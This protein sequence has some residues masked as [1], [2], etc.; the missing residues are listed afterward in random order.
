M[1]SAYETSHIRKLQ[2]Q[3]KRMQ[4][5]TFTNWI[6]NIF[7][8]GRV[9]IKIQNLYTELADGTHLL[10]LLEI[11]SGESLPPPSRGRMRAHFLEN[12]SRAL[13]FLK[14][15]VPIPLIGPEN[16]VDGDQTLILGLIWVI[17]LRFQISHI[18][19]DREEFGASA[20]LLS[21]KEALLVW[22]Q[23]KTACYANVN[24]TD[25][26]R[27]WSDGLGFGALIH[28]HRP[29]LL[30]YCSLRPERP[31]HN[32][33]L[34]F[35]VAEQELGIAQLLDPEDVAALQPDE[36]SIMTYISLYYHHFSRL[37][38]EQTVQRRLAK[39][40]LQLQETEELQTQY[41]QLVGDL[42]GWIAEKQAQL[43]AHDFPNSLP[44][45][46]QLLVTFA[47]FRTQEKPPRLQQRGAIE[48][49]LF[50]LQTAFRAQN[51]KPFL[52]PEGLGPAELSQLWTCLE[53]AEA[54][55]SQALLQRILQLERLEI[56]VRRFQHKAALRESFL[57]DTEHML[58][59]AA[60]ASPPASLATVEV[61]AQRLGMLEASILPQEGRFQALAEITD[62][63]QQQQ[64]PGWEEVACR[65]LEITGRWERLLERLQG[66]KKQMAD[67]QAMLGL[68][69][70]VESASNQLKEL[71]VLA[72]STA[73]G[74]LLAET[75]ELLQKHD[76][77]EA[78]VSA[79]GAHVRHLALQTMELDSSL[80]TGVEVLQAKAQSL[81]QLHWSLVSLVKARRAL[82]EQ[83]LQ[84]AEFLHHCEEEEA[85]LKERGRLLEDDG[86]L[87]P[88]LS[89]IRAALQKH[90]A[91]EAELRHH[92]N[93]CTDLVRRGCDLSAR[94]PPTRPDPRERA[95][96]LQ[97]TWQW[98]RAGAARRGARLQAALLARQY[99]AD[100][101][102]A[103]SWLREQ[104]LAMKSAP[105]GPDPEATEALLLHHRQLE[106]AV[107][108]FGAEMRQLDEQARAAAAQV[109]LTVVSALSSP[110]KALSH[111]GT[112][113]E[114]SCY[115]SP[116]GTRKMALS[117]GPDAIFDPNTI[118]Q[119]QDCLSRDYE[120][121]RALAKHH[122]AR[123]EEAI[124]LWGFHGF[125]GEL[126]SWLEKQ[127]ALLQALQPQ[128][129]NLEV[130]QLTYENFLTTLA[131][132]R[133]YWAEVS[134]NAE[135]LKQRYPEG[136][137]RIQQQQEELSQR[138]G[139]MEAL[140]KEKET[141]LA[142]TTDV[143]TFLHECG[144]TQV[145]LQDL[146][147]QLE[148]LQLGQ[149]KDSHRTL[150]LAQQ[151]MLMLERRV[152]YLQR[153]AMKAEELGP[154]ES[155][156]L[157]EEVEPLWELLERGQQ[158][159]ARQA[160]AWAE[161]RARQSF[162]QESQQLLLWVEGIWAQLRREEKVMD[163][164]SAQQLLME[165]TDLQVE[166]QLQQERLQQLEAQG[167]TLSVLDSPDSQEVART[168][169][170][171]GEQGPGLQA[172][173]EQRRQRLQ[174]GLEL[175]RFGGDVDGFTATCARHEAFL[176]RDKLGD[177]VG[178]AQSLLQQHRD[179]GWLLGI[180]GHQA[181]AL[182][183]RGEKLALSQHPAAHKVQEQL[184]SVQAQWTR[185]QERSEQTRRRLLASLQLQEWQQ[186]V[187]G[188]VLWIEE[189]G[190]RAAEEP[191]REP[192]DILQQAAWH[193][194][195]KRELLAS[196]GHVEG[197]QQAGRRL[198]SDGHCAGEAVQASLQG[199]SSKWEELKNKLARQG[200]RLLQTRQLLGLLQDAKEKMKQLE[201]SL[202]STETGQDLG[203]SRELQKWHGQLESESQA[204]ASKMAAVV[205]QAHQGL[206]SQTIVEETQKYLQRFKSL[207]GPLAARRL[208]L[209]ASV[210]LH[211]FYQLS[212]LELTWVAERM[213]R[214][215]STQCLNQAQRLCHKH[216]E[217]GAEM[218]A[219]QGQ[220]QHVLGS[221]QSLAASG[222]PEASRVLEQCQKLEGHWA[223]L[224]RTWE[225]QAQCLQQA[226]ALQQCFLAASELEDWVK[227]KQPLVDSEDCGG[228]E[229][230]TSR[231]IKKNQ[232]LQ[233][234]LALCWSSMEKL[235]QR[236]QIL[237][238]P[239]APEHLRVVRERLWEQ[240]RAL[241][242]RAATRGRE[243]EGTLKLHEFMGEAEELRT[244]LASQKQ[245]AG[246]GE[247]LGEDHEHI[248][249]LCTEFTR[250][251]RRVELGALRVAACRQ[252]AESLQELGHRAA[253]DARQT[254]QHL[255]AAWSELWE[256][257]QARGHQLQ[258]AEVTLRV[259]RDLLEALTQVQE[260]A[261]S[262]PS[263][264]APDLHGLEAQL[265]RH[266]ELEHELRGAGQQLQELLEAA[267]AV[268]KLG[269]GPQAQAV[270]QR[271]EALGQAWEA[272]KLHVEQRRTRLEQACLLARFHRAVQDYTSW[273]AA[274]WREL[275]GQEGSQEPGHGLPTLLS[276]HRQLRAELEAREELHQ[277]ASQ[278]G[279][280]ALLAVV[281]TP[282]KEVQ[283]G[284]RALRDE[285]EQVFQAWEQKEEK[286]QAM[287]REQLFLRKCGHLDQILTVQE[288]S[289]KTGALGSSV[290]EVEQLIRKHKTFQNVLTA[291][292]E[293]EA[294]L[295]EQAKT[296]GGP[297]VQDRL[298]TV[299][300]H[301]AQV[302]D[303][304]ESR[305]QALHTCL[306]M[307]GF[308][309]AVTQ[310]QDWIEER[311]RQLREPIPPGDL[312]DKLRLLRK[313]QAFEAE[314]QAHEEVITSV[315]KDGE[316]LLAQSPPQAG[317]VSQ[318][319]QDLQE[320]WRKLRQAVVL[321]GQD[322]EDR[323]K[324]L[325]FLR[326]ADL[327]DAWIQEMEA[328]V[329]LGEQGQ[330]LEHCLQLRKRLRE[331]PGLWAEDTVDDIH[332]RSISDLS[333][334]LGNL[335]PEQV[336]T[337]HK[338]RQQLNS[339]WKSFRGNLLWYQQQLEGALEIHTL[340]RELDGVTEQIGEKAAL[341]QALDYG[342][343]Q[344]SLQRL[345]R[346]HKELEQEIGL[347]QAQVESLE[348]A[349]GR[350]CQRSP[351]T[352]H[353]LSSKQ[354][355]VT[356]S[357]WQLWRGA[358]KRRES[359]EALYE[360]QSLQAELRHL[361]VWAQG[362]RAEMEAQS[363]PSS[364]AEA[365]RRL[366][367]HQELKAELDLKTN[368]ISLARSTGQ[369]LLAAGHPAPPDLRQALAGLDQ[370]LNSLERA[371]Q[372]HQLQLQQALELQ[373]V[374]SSVEQM[375]IWLCSQEACPT[376]KGLGD[377]WAA[378][379]TLL[380][381]HEVLERG[382]EAQ[383]EKM[384][385]LEAAARRLHQAGYPEAQG[386][387][388]RCQAMLLRKEAL[389]ERARTR[390]RQLEEL[391]QLQTFLQDSFEVATWLR[392][393]HSVALEE[394]WRDPALLQAQLRKQRS[395]QAELDASVHHHQ[396][397]QKEGQRLLQE[398]HPASE[399]IRERLRELGE[400]WDELQA[401]SRRKAAMLQVVCEALHL[402]RRVEELESWLEPVEVEL[403][404]PVRDQDQPGLD[405]LLGAQ[406]E[407]EVTVE[408][409]ARQAQWLWG[410]AQVLTGES[411]CLAQD[412]K[413]QALQ[414]LRRF[415][416][417]REPLRE[418]RAALETRSRLL[419]FFRD[420]DDELAW[421]RAKLPLATTQDC[422]QSLSAVRQLQE[423]HQ[424]LE[425][426]MS[427][428]E[429]LTKAVVA[430]GHQLAQAGP[431]AT[432]AAARV[433]QLE[434]AVGG[435]RAEA[436]RRRLRL[437]QAQEAQQFLMELQEAEAWLEE[438]GCVLELKDVGQSAEAMRAFLR[439]LEATQRDLEAFGLRIESLQQTAALL[440]SRQ[441][442]ES[443]RALAR[444][445]AVR[446][447]YSGLLLRADGRQQGLREQLQLHQLERE[448]LLLEAWLASKAATA[449]S[450][451]HGQDLEAV[452][453][454][455]EKF[456]AFRKEAQSL[457]Q[458][459]V[460]ALR[461][462]ADSLER[463]APR[464]TP[465]IQ[466][467][468][469][470]IEAAWER[471][472]GAIKARIQSLAIAREVRGFEQ[473][474]AEL[475]EWMQEKATQTVRDICDHSLSSVQT[476]QQQHRGLE[477]DL[478]AV[479]KEVARVQMEA[480]R[481]GQLYPA[482]QEGLCKQLAKVEEAWATL[483]MK[484]RER[485]RQLEQ[486]AQGH[487]FLSCC[488]ELLAWAQEKKALVSSEELA[489]D[490]VGAERL[491]VQQV[492][493]GQELQE[494]CLRAHDVQQEGRQLI[495]SGHFMS[496]EVAA[497]LRELEGQLQALTE[498]C[499]LRQ[500]RC[501]ENWGLQKLRQELDR[502]EAWLAS[503]EVLL[504]DPNYG[505][506]VS[507]VQLLL[508]RHQDLEKL[509]AAQEEKFAQLQRKAG[510]DWKLLQQV[511]GLE[512]R[513]A[514]HRL[515][516]PKQRP[517]GS[518]WPG[519]Q[520]TETRDL[521]PGVPI[522]P[523]IPSATTVSLEPVA[524][525]QE[526]SGAG[527]TEDAKDVPT[528][529]GFLEFQQQLRS[530]QRQPCL[531]LWDGCHG[532]LRGS[533]L[534]LFWDKRTAAEVL[535]SGKHE[536]QRTGPQGRADMAAVTPLMSFQNMAPV[537][538]LD[539][540][541]AQCER[542]GH[543]HGRKHAFSLRLSSRVE[544]P[545]AAPSEGQAESGIPA[546]S[547]TAGPALGVSCGQWPNP[548]PAGRMPG[549]HPCPRS[550]SSL[551]S[552]GL[553]PETVCSVLETGKSTIKVPP[554]SG[555]ARSLSL[556]HPARPGGL[557]AEHTAEGVPGLAAPLRFH[558]CPLTSSLRE[559]PVSTH[560][561]PQPLEFLQA[562]GPA[563]APAPGS[564]SLPC[565][566]QAQGQDPE[567]NPEVAA[568]LRATNK[569]NL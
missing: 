145:Q 14:A 232:A 464:C 450:Q 283:E 481:L 35:R 139:Q 457:G 181:E 38:Q 124:A 211:E 531:S 12:S 382:L 21:A 285:R 363:T 291:Q 71:Q 480:C 320:H 190:L 186:D 96:A 269:P 326:R 106:R 439:R 543:Q 1:D 390:R 15:K 206:T 511:T 407:L 395:L 97:G 427:S 470:R 209:Q 4:E 70:E 527:A 39:I 251:Q 115:S 559:M 266:E 473:A 472:D 331:L 337:I 43:E 270:Q 539:L 147:L 184:Q 149:S 129:H 52:P 123:L 120:G 501:E 157:Q 484:A 220:V 396:R 109:S 388:G 32:L 430:E 552:D 513:S 411:L 486:A 221:G 474:A 242:E 93:V 90:K 301:R 458:A 237:A 353:R 8:H 191:S 22:C 257:T 201:R 557:P 290:E 453:M 198:L 492:E 538:T 78:Q 402:R 218:R 7:Q 537:A 248:L 62:V 41:K 53:R 158:Q 5:K 55:R 365:R 128:A 460:Q 328:M 178:E 255:Q 54:S 156:S 104:R 352:A 300:E 548:A 148:I 286:L 374:L 293:K 194:A 119:T 343:D 436:T 316:A 321:R 135:Q 495:D 425:N 261:T 477:R 189:K 152:H 356:D 556:E 561:Q 288:I 392:E 519:V 315:T 179:F 67:L 482:A 280:Q 323:W 25:F 333:L 162:L 245:A 535:G 432:E 524:Q 141:Q 375:E 281:G 335:D 84:Q 108:A 431:F 47:H 507:D 33:A 361:S 476:L 505:H 451:D 479:E 496:L 362:L 19:L 65:Q 383:A 197:L 452:T 341:V 16:I 203:S 509:L 522:G 525:Q 347:L 504:L 176:Q 137:P 379:E 13:A 544:T 530:A 445:Q 518:W 254:Q 192:S 215:G 125:C 465:Q 418:R 322:L 207:Q 305:G 228:E 86:A 461:E 428:H 318:R 359:L 170:L 167:Q 307:T 523:P 385:T 532:T 400:L 506:N 75:M 339:R 565:P 102:D 371:W 101:A 327:T 311:V 528:M 419:Q 551:W 11:I 146:I 569:D 367:E 424:N 217:L 132:G 240:L 174:E 66:Q 354:R 175:Q 10:R 26:S 40:L 256:L 268:Q 456:D 498:A 344:E 276:S 112:W 298:H 231:L 526:P 542:P 34:A 126:R 166:I 72:S 415:E 50:R 447:A 295:C 503:R 564:P 514:G 185:V 463:M 279:Q 389:V 414:L 471:V 310:A 49:L 233:Q 502:A 136:I 369:R 205:S 560:S 31:L 351:G 454:L 403:R 488:R 401:N 219:H 274:V 103:A 433:Q 348:R 243:L 20:A 406:G 282:I 478:A 260:K 421:V 516:S 469:S 113:S 512:P 292:D 225:A 342:K 73:C 521:Q 377:S 540:R 83:S 48:A 69:H 304:A 317:E 410:Q 360:A 159:V 138:W 314:I 558:A 459:K 133:G 258:D 210:E 140:K 346:K 223:E 57:M 413:D 250:F 213:A 475:Q 265:R 550:L 80:G 378:A 332:I 468:R 155:R 151:K 94:G 91:L 398:G 312:K 297:I 262:L 17:I 246:L 208:Q 234:E 448:A 489:G 79:H 303:L 253:P 429:A 247:S 485:G 142:H 214:V 153:T 358:Q 515:T 98:L 334:K 563:Q 500:E 490:M 404:A 555:S 529:V 36:R 99:S 499:T 199:L 296:L 370:E 27:S 222:H 277:R 60:A 287:Q 24:I 444:M 520:L 130:T 252:L 216:E 212:N 2:A 441:N 278:L 259:H 273:A 423:K 131:V 409:Q 546:L 508:C 510:V 466:A 224:E 497:C 195:T 467:Q 236:A 105:C 87:G 89:Q 340:S 408:G 364:P 553:H 183:A 405:K 6:N 422:G 9:A 29:D 308:T 64:H 263:E 302:K 435:L 144:S 487:A 28:A 275:Q 438:R 188:L 284:L 299:L 562:E 37:H 294:A 517:F 355:E 434:S 154:P 349:V 426:E 177:D 85:W 366:E 483:D 163:V 455:E 440:E 111:L 92:Q 350:F 143:C 357:W 63:L 77:L 172:A 56:L 547:S 462:L 173:W 45:M 289:L 319:L 393:K 420:A 122:R 169:S 61:A 88:D 494:P 493:L 491:L 117:A 74:Q 121:L 82:L 249:H 244:W 51:R 114:V 533:S 127:T 567:P 165:H 338:R 271:Q 226:V 267:S 330:D 545:W 229:A 196:S 437:Q 42:L 412:V 541:G 536:R 134:S 168:L 381:K 59:R 110:K 566:G 336:K 58:D 272:L 313:H 3:H 95:K 241:R 554:D 329:N 18:S 150:Q 202:Q 68:L 325:E 399:T 306:L 100:A 417:L 187:A 46:R 30:D 345:I 386:A 239:G 118:L 442:P 568:T 397:L 324:F 376:S 200:D 443:G 264:V 76:L 182:R 384:S 534:S 227:E 549:T 204:L 394:G 164:A 372:D 416:C 81:A 368:R 387:L 449:E 160:R 235:D 116:P 193:E 180:L 238:G 107:Q 446:E 161:A 44:A 309:R 23:R 171:L 373:L 391:Q 230:A 380:R